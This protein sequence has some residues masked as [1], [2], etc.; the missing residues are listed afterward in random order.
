MTVMGGR[1]KRRH[2]WALTDNHLEGSPQHLWKE[3]VESETRTLAVI[4]PLEREFSEHQLL[5]H[6]SFVV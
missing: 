5:F 4:P 3:S 1:G 2:L 6:I